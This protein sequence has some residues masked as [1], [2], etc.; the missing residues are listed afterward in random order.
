M[1]YIKHRNT[2]RNSTLS[3]R[4]DYSITLGVPQLLLNQLPEVSAPCSLTGGEKRSYWF[5][6]SSTFE[7]Q[8]KSLK[9]PAM[10]AKCTSPNQVDEAQHLDSENRDVTK[11]TQPNSRALWGPPCYEKIAWRAWNGAN[12][13]DFSLFC[14]Y[15]Y[16]LTWPL[17]GLLTFTAQR[18]PKL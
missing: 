11:T 16:I 5:P 18:F 13:A 3:D 6:V 15:K 17:W 8:Q 2:D 12:W 7:I 4:K 9:G 14:L 10:V 1:G